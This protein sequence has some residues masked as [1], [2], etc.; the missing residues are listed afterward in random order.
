[1]G[2]S[3]RRLATLV[4]AILC[5]LW[6]LLAVPSSTE[7][8]RDLRTAD[9]VRQTV[10]RDP[11][12][13]SPGRHALRGA[14]AV[15]QGDASSGAVAQGGISAGSVAHATSTGA[16][17]AAALPFASTSPQGTPPVGVPPH[18]AAHGVPRAAP[19]EPQLSAAAVVGL[20]AAV[21][22]PVRFPAAPAAPA[23]A[24]TA[25]SVPARGLLEG[26]PR[27]ERAPPGGAHG[28]RVPR[29]PPSTR[30]S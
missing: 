4:P 19:Q 1:M 20:P 22:N 2:G 14:G 7:P 28:P 15:A 24:P 3:A 9:A 6:S 8:P 23:A 11:V 17:R 30:H 21:E 26:D 18:A 10:L 13:A 12:P 29:G 5:V 25:P 27:R 16:V